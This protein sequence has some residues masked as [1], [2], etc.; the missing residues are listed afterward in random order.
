MRKNGH[1]LT[2]GS[3]GEEGGPSAHGVDVTLKQHK[4]G[5]AV[6]KQK[7]NKVYRGRAKVSNHMRR[8][9]SVQIN[10]SSL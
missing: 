1:K 10:I 8:T 5:Q 2:H 6:K 4:Q 3:T 7:G 9:L